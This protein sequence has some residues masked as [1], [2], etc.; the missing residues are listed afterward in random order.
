MPTGYTD[1]IKDGISFP[2]FALNCARAFG[3][4]VTLRD[5]PD[6]PIPEVF[7]PTNWHLERIKEAEAELKRLEAMSYIEALGAMK[8]EV[9]EQLQYHREGIEK[10]RKLKESYEAMLAQVNDWLP[11]TKDHYWL[12]EF[13]QQQIRDSIEF[14]CNGTYHEDAILLLEAITVDKWL[15][16]KIESAKRQIIYNTE[17]Q[18]KEVVRTDSRTEWI[19]DLRKSLASNP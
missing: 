15:E 13:M 5:E 14:D 6:E 12:K 4:C 2:E 8:K 3:A 1:K 17:Q 18:D 9:S 16:E 10:D 19:R 11:P 7:E